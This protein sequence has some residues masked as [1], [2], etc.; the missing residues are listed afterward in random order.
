MTE[1]GSGLS[2]K[3]RNWKLSQNVVVKPAASRPYSH[4]SCVWTAGS[5]ICVQKPAW[6]WCMFPRKP[7]RETPI[8][9]MFSQV[10]RRNMDHAERRYFLR[11]P[12]DKPK[13]Y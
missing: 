4:V 5:K 3:A 12:K 8:E 6:G 9:R 7:H 11:R 10:F 1:G 13:R 2:S